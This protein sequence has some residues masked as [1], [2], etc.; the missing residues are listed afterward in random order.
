MCS[1]NQKGEIRFYTSLL[2]FS[3]ENGFALFNGKVDTSEK[4][5]YEVASSHAA[6]D[7]HTMLTKYGSD[8]NSLEPDLSSAS[9]RRNNKCPIQALNTYRVKELPW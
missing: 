6:W 4:E 2:E 8:L 7:Q 5:C 9:R 1:G 3:R